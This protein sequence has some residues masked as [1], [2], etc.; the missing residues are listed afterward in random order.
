MRVLG[1]ENCAAQ[2]FEV[3]GSFGQKV[4]RPLAIKINLNFR[5]RKSFSSYRLEAKFICCHN[6]D[7]SFYPFFKKN[8]YELGKVQFPLRFALKLMFLLV[9]KKVPG[10]AFKIV[11]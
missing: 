11:P 7:S 2:K 10:K 6:A 3:I 9:C 5:R 1:V 4:S 8:F